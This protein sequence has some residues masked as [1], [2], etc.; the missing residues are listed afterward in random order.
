MDEEGWKEKI[1][2]KDLY[3]IRGKRSLWKRQI[4]VEGEERKTI[5]GL[6]LNLTSIPTYLR[7]QEKG[8]KG[9]RK[10]REKLREKMSLQNSST[11]R[12]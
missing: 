6:R 4:N 10:N 8:W 9:K 2:E 5:K 11:L 12:S 3:Y 1:M 7:Q